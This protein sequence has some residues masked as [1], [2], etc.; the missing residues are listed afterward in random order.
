MSVETNPTKTLDEMRKL[1]SKITDAS[2][3]QKPIDPVAAGRLAR[4]FQELDEWLSNEGD[5]PA[6][7]AP[8]E[9]GY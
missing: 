1:A 8:E 3:A 7:W 4:M 6:Q 5:A 2:E 9:R